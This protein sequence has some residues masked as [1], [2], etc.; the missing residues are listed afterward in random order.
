M[1]QM[2]GGLTFGI[3]VLSACGSSSGGSFNGTVA[4]YPLHVVESVFMAVPESREDDAFTLILLSDRPGTCNGIRTGTWGKNTTSF[5]IYL[6]SG[7]PSVSPASPGTY[8]LLT[9][10]PNTGVAY[11]LK[12]DDQCRAAAGLSDNS[13][14]ANS[15]SVVLQSIDASPGRYARGSY[16]II[17]RSGERVTGTF[18]AA[19]CP[20]PTSH[21]SITCG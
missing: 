6:F 3:L 16:D 5:G 4:G 7:R 2:G 21:R 17:L 20:P 13:V 19:Y 10:E 12:Q 9:D 15:G 1:K 8:H 14:P 18:D 11:F